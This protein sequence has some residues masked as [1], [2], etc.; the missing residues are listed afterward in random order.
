MLKIVF[1]GTPE[2]AVPAL[3]ALVASDHAVAAVYTQPDRPAGRGRKLTPSPVKHCALEHGLPV[4]QPVNFR[5]AADLQA[6]ES[7]HADLMVVAAYGLLLPRAVL[8]APR[9]GC[10]N[11]HASLLPHWRGASPIQ[12]AILAGDKRTGITLMKMDEG[13]DTG[14][15]IA[16]REIDID[17]E[18][19]AGELQTELARL[20]AGLLIDTLGDIEAA[21]ESARPQDDSEASYAPRL[22][23]RQAELDWNKPCEILLREIRA[24]NPWP[25]S[26]TRLDDDNLRL[27]RAEAASGGDGVPGEVVTHDRSGVLV[28]C[29]DGSIRITELQF[30][31]RRRCDASQA[32]N[33]RNLTGCLLGARV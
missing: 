21:L 12:Q 6:L 18:W 11:L 29:G 27:W 14:D 8:Q 15:V 19:S 26:Y 28:R 13:L 24:F 33:A 25:V 16:T 31:G 7:I 10:V 20:G 22:D 4:S 32:L 5:A 3:E 30:A 17:P 1:A 2:F 23:K 9:L